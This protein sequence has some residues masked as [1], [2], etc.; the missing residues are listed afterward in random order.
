[1]KNQFIT[2]KIKSILSLLAACAIVVCLSPADTQASPLVD[3][4]YLNSIVDED[5]NPL[6][7]YLTPAEKLLMQQQAAAKT[8]EAIPPLPSA[9]PIG[10]TWTPGEYEAVYGPLIAWEAGAYYALLT[11]F[12]VGVTTDP[13]MNSLAFVIVSGPSQEATCTSTLAGA[14]ADM[15]RVKFIYYNLN[16]VW[17]RD[18]GPRYTYENGEPAITDH[19]YNRTT[20]PLD[21]AFPAFLST[22]DVPFDLDEPLYDLGLVHG[23]GNFH[24]FSDANAFVSSLALDP[25]ENGSV[26][27]TEQEVK[28]AFRDVMNVDVT[29]FTRLP[30]SVD[31]TGHI[32]MWLL[33][34]SDTDVIVSEF[35]GDP[36]KT[37][38]DDAA[39]AL[40]AMG[41]TVHRTPAWTNSGTHYT[42]TNAAIINTRVF[43]PEYG[44]SRDATALAVFQNAMPDHEIFQ[45]DCSSII[46]Q[47]GAIHCVMKHVYAPATPF[48]EVLSPNGGEVLG[49]GRQYDIKW[50]VNDDDGIDGLTVDIYYSTDGGSAYP[51]TIETGL[52]HNGHYKWTVPATISET[53]KIKIVVRDTDTNT[54]Q[55][56]SDADFEIAWLEPPA[57]YD[58]S[59]ITAP[60]STHTAEDGEIDVDDA[61]IENG[62]FPA[63]RDTI[64][65]WAN[66]AE[67]SSAEYTNLVGSDD[68]RYQGADPGYG[69]NAAMI[70]EFTIDQDPS[71]VKQIDV[72]VELGRNASTDYGWIYIWNYNTSSYMV[73]GAQ[74]GTADYVISA[75][76]TTNP[77]DYI[78]PGT[79][80]LTIFAVNEDDSDWIR[81]DD[82]TVT[83]YAQG[84]AVV[85][86][87]VGT[88]RAGAEETIV[89][90]GLTVG[91]VTYQA[92]LAVDAN[93]V[94]SQDPNSGTSV[95]LD[96]EIDLIVSSGLP[97]HTLTIDITGNGSVTKVPNQH[98][99]THGT[100]VT[101]MPTATVG[102][103]FTGWSGPDAG[104]LSDNGNG[105][106]DLNMDDNKAVTANFAIDQHD[107]TPSSTVGGSVTD[108]G[109]AGPYTYNYDTVV[110]LVAEA[111]AGYHFV[112]WTGDTAGIDNINSATTTVTMQADYAIV[113]KFE[114]D[115]PPIP[116]GPAVMSDPIMSDGW[117]PFLIYKD[118]VQSRIGSSP[119]AYGDWEI[120]LL[121]EE[122][123][124]TPVVLN[125]NYIWPNADDPESWLYG[126]PNSTFL[127]VFTKET[128]TVEFTVDYAPTL[129]CDYDKYAGIGM[130]KLYLM[131]TSD[132]NN[133]TCSITDL[134]INGKLIIN[135]S[136][137]VATDIHCYATISGLDCND[138]SLTGTITFNYTGQPHSSEIEA[139]IAFG[140][141][142][143]PP[144][145]PNE[146]WTLADKASI[147]SEGTQENPW[148]VKLES[149]GNEVPP[150]ASV[151][152][153]PPEPMVFNDVNELSADYSMI[154][155]SFGGGA[156][157]F[158]LLIDWNDS[159]IADTGDKYAL[160]YWGTPPEF[161]DSPMP[162]WN[163]TGNLYDSNDLR[164][165]LSQFGVPSYTTIEQA[166]SL[167]G[168]KEVFE[169]SLVLNGGWMHDQVLLADYITVDGCIYDAY[170]DV[171]ETSC[172][173]DGSGEV[174]MADLCIMAFNWLRN[175][176]LLESCDNA[177]IAPQIPD[178]IV[179]NIDFAALAD[180][181]LEGVEFDLAPPEP[182]VMTWASEPNAIDGTNSITMTATTA[183]DQSGVEYYFKN[184][185]LP[186]HNSSWRLSST[187]V[188]TELEPGTQY[189]YQVKAR[190]M[191]PNRNE[192]QYSAPASAV[193][194]GSVDAIEV[195]DVFV[196]IP[197]QDA[198]LW[199]NGSGTGIGFDRDDSNNKALRLGDYDTDQGYRIV[200]SF[201]TSSIPTDARIISA[202]LQLTCGSKD[203]ISPFDGWG[204]NCV[205]D[206]AS[207][208]F[209]GS[210]DIENEDWHN[211]A[212]ALAVAE[213]TTDPGPED[214]IISTEF[215]AAGN[216]Y[217]NT[218]GSTQL[219]V[220]FT[221]PRLSNGLSDYLGFYSAE[222]EGPDIP[223]QP[224]RR[225]QLI[226][227]YK[228]RTPTMAI[229]G[230]AE[231]D[232][233]VYDDGAGIGEGIVNDSGNKALR[234]GDY[235]GNEGY[236]VIVS[237]DTSVF[238]ENYTIEGVMLK[239]ASGAMS[240][241]NPFNWGGTCNI[242]LAVP[243]FNTSEDL[244][245]GDW[246]ALATVADVASF[247]SAPADPNEGLFMVSNR[248]SPEGRMNINLDGLTQLRVYF[249]TPRNNNGQADYLGFYAAEAVETRKPRLLLEYSID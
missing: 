217:I 172:D 165:D 174:T 149:L 47:A 155:G 135:G 140:A 201:D 110:D 191:S 7:R 130:D 45:I 143:P 156:P 147:V 187:Y 175:D 23:G 87:V 195:E 194:Q 159:G 183:T 60:S 173:I 121:T 126:E 79:G 27:Y 100:E 146:I 153:T 29:I 128:G 24:A 42:Y 219:R 148:V 62:T 189:T 14:G 170:L 132:A 211:T 164:V 192:T 223:G 139:M 182:N 83:I 177:D 43:V 89:A 94:I 86:D 57:I 113:A 178:G 236:R 244:E 48:G 59:G 141:P 120:G 6:P 69:D 179:N 65:G 117:G 246:E 216:S 61:M 228:S 85:P 76:V 32:D 67:A 204:G 111:D 16:S 54:G 218:Y 108:P 203:G 19:T 169:V 188:D 239:L 214:P 158:K 134:E 222:E 247:A 8:L 131:A 13:N 181:W 46:S 225:P 230:I 241:T 5:P 104:D 210:E 245:S 55:D 2:G 138:F 115:Q 77:S 190:D 185:T 28:D 243:Y 107:L 229:P 129:T 212:D 17:I 96:T 103:S 22:D 196:S 70:F 1:M 109:E 224:D 200:L 231:H 105:T 248:F 116:G 99:Y 205:I 119:G 136:N 160:V 72:S 30:D 88:S 11:E 206:I 234:L 106:W 91:S 233:R 122:D 37:I 242:D 95:P 33:P 10:V 38:T 50:I 53:C 97:R 150:W 227:R 184:A 209:G 124:F 145:E 133:Y 171:A 144:P 26:T 15:D 64:T 176:C 208:Y 220:Q 232:G 197:P 56:V 198:R 92:S 102:Y 80:R 163:N 84:D 118:L 35:T 199:D 58:F 3:Q 127:L 142:G 154:E 235:S 34:V 78:E 31:A 114:I 151:V 162:N 207:P 39:D 71:D 161:T 9:A 101:L 81:I 63:R 123:G 66:W 238:P 41:Y 68:N 221:V 125:N 90:A 40:E 82:I 73:L 74:S 25:Y 98:T 51:Y 186:T 49:V 93:D 193:A 21:N 36:G 4:D 18:Y 215:N 137:L 44:D 180:C 157:C 75:G 152:F 213:F 166:K 240:G 167:F 237:F 12:I 202:K 112:N 52:P 20:R 249:T 168:N 226:V